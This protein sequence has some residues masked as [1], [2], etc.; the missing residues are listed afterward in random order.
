MKTNAGYDKL[1]AAGKKKFDD[2]WAAKLKAKKEADA[3]AKTDIGY[4]AMTAEAKT[5]YDAEFLKWKKAVFETCKT[6]KTKIECRDA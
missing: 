4:A 5:V 1:D 2:E 6:D 3:K